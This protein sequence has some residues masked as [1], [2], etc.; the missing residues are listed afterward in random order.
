GVVQFLRYSFKIAVAITVTVVK[1]SLKEV[2]D[3]FRLLTEAPCHGQQHE[4]NDHFRFHDSASGLG[5]ARSCIFFPSPTIH[6]ISSHSKTVLD[7]GLRMRSPSRSI[8]ITR[9]LVRSLNPELLMSRP[10]SL[11][12][13]FTT[14]FFRAISSTSTSEGITGSFASNI[15][16]NLCIC[17]SV[18]ITPTRSRGNSLLL[19]PGT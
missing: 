13:S 15:G 4:H 5:F 10:L 8:P 18:A 1:T 11:V 9:P 19:R 17:S 6:T 16:L 14:I 12:C 3:N 2:I 7:S